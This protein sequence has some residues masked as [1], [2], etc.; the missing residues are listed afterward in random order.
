MKN[1]K[2][3]IEIDENIAAACLTADQWACK[4][5]SMSM[6]ELQVLAAYFQARRKY[7]EKVEDLINLM[8][9]S[10]DEQDEQDEQAAA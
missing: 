6:T 10:E 7:L 5:K 3:D 1:K 2:K 9:P 4:K 8:L